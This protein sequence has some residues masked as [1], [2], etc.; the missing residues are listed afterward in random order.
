MRDAQQR[1]GDQRHHGA[2]GRP[3]E[4]PPQFGAAQRRQPQPGEHQHRKQQALLAPAAA[5]RVAHAA[6]RQRHGDRQGAE[7]SRAGALARGPE[8]Q[9]RHQRGAGNEQHQ[10]R[11]TRPF[12]AAGV[13]PD[14]GSELPQPAVH[15]APEGP[16]V[17]GCDE[18][19]RHA[20]GDQ[21]ELEREQRHHHGHGGPRDSRPPRVG[22]RETCPADRP[23]PERQDATAGTRHGRNGHRHF[24]WR[25]VQQVHVGERGH[26]GAREEDHQPH[27][28]RSQSLLLARTA[29]GD[30]RGPGLGPGAH[31]G[32]RPGTP[33][34]A[35][36]GAPRDGEQHV[37]MGAREG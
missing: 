15:R 2:G 8:E 28:Q 11:Q 6:Q 36:N 16:P 19:D 17:P 27:P 13:W 22:P 21:A 34:E 1:R 3:A 29:N 12:R 37:G 35:L 10:H 24:R 7:P 4:R 5:V 18:V 14:P 32:G 31:L 9:Q 25:F 30:G 23:Q 20:H 33:V 26:R